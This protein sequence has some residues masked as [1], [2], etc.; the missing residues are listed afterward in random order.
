M[1]NNIIESGH[2]RI[3]VYSESLD[4]IKGVLFIKDLLPHIDQGDNFK[5]QSL[6]RQ[7]YFVPENKKINDLLRR[8][9]E[10]ENQSGIQGIERRLQA[11]EAIVVD[12]E[13]ILK[14]KFRK[15]IG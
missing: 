5:W 7:S 13:Y 2:S 4:N 6:L 14:N 10:L 3:P 11:L 8:I 15:A 12:D 9:D 1:L